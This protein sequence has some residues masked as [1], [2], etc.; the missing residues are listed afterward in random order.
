[1]CRG[2][3]VA[4]V[5]WDEL[6]L[7]RC[8]AMYFYFYNTAPVWV[9]SIMPHSDSHNFPGVVLPI[10]LLVEQA[11][12]WCLWRANW[13][14]RHC[15]LASDKHA[16]THEC[17]SLH[18]HWHPPQGTSCAHVPSKV[19]ARR[20]TKLCSSSVLLVAISLSAH[21][22]RWVWIAGGHG[23][24]TVMEGGLPPLSIIVLGADCSYIHIP[25]REVTVRYD[26]KMLAFG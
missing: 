15:L 19:R 18:L 12:G 9:S 8:N 22:P 6:T 5:G 7:P 21:I 11:G 23:L 3:L 10:S 2:L 17:L 4:E 13:V 1:M 25:Y 14:H 20:I 16:Q 24:E 26:S